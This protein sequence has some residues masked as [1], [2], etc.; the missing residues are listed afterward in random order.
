MSRDKT[1]QAQSV[2]ALVQGWSMD[3]AKRL[4]DAFKASTEFNNQLE[5]AD[6][7]PMARTRLNGV[8]NGGITPSVVQFERICEILEIDRDEILGVPSRGRFS[9]PDYNEPLSADVRVDGHGFNL[10][11]R[12]EVS[13]SAG[14]G[15]IP[16]A[17]QSSDGLMF[18]RPWLLRRG[19]AADLSG[20]V[21]V[22]GD[23]MAPTIQDGATV[24]LQFQPSITTEGVYVF[25]R[26]GQVFVKRLHPLEIA[27]DGRPTSVAVISDNSEYPPE[28]LAGAALGEVRIIGRVR[29]ALNEL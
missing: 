17:E 8:F 12:Y 3:A 16:S 9:A 19:I 25:R 11:K 4:H 28:V 10:V 18:P 21:K 29:L 20:L 24:L 5:L 22:K 6:E 13:V 7:V 2:R 23:S 27:P 26:D 1:R 14:P 15:V